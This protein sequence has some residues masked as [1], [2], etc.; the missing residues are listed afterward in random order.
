MS[1]DE[2]IEYSRS[3]GALYTRVSAKIDSGVNSL[4]LSIAEAVIK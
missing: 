1:V 4:F 3:I 2:A